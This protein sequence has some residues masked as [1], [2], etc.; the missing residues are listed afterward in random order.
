MTR[1]TRPSRRTLGRVAL[2]PLLLAAGVVAAPT[3]PADPPNA[4]GSA[5]NAQ[6]L[7]SS[8][9]A[10]NGNP[11]ASVSATSPRPAARETGRKIG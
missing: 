1:S 8:G 7:V 3:S 9:G 10:S 5:P 11:P 6:G 2:V 4:Q